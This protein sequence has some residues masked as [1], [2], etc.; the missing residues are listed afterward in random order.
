M[1]NL[2]VKRPTRA[3]MVRGGCGPFV[4]S[5]A[6]HLVQGMEEAEGERLIA[7]A[8]LALRRDPG[9]IEAH[10]IL[11]DSAP[12]QDLRLQHLRTAV[13]TGDELFGPIAEAYGDDM[14]WWSF[15]G[16]RPY[17]RAIHALGQALVDAGEIEQAR[18]CFERLLAMNPHDNQGIR[19]EL[20][21]L[22]NVVQLPRI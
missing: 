2:A 21:R 19:F 18:A 9:C 5:P 8:V 20:E 1:K 3:R 11:S 15:P 7:L 4:E 22:E 12:T 13:E 17:M 10:H 16:T 14:C 6:D